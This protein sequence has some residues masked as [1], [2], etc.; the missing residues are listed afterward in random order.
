MGLIALNTG[1]D[2]TIL[3]GGNPATVLKLPA[4]TTIGGSS[5][6]A[7]GYVTSTSANAMGAGRQGTTNPVLN[8]DASAALVVTGIN[9]VGAAAAA[10]LALVVTSSG[11]DE[12]LTLDAKGAGTILLNGTAT[13]AVLVGDA[14]NPAFSVVH[15]SEGTGVKVTSAAAASGVAV[16]AISSGTDENLTHNAKGAGTLTINGVAT[17]ATIIPKGRVTPEVTTI[18]GDGAITIQS[19][20]VFLTKGSPA[21]I[22]L[23]APS[24]NDGVRICVIGASDFQHVI[25]FTGTTLLDGTTGANLK[26]TLAAFAGSGLVVI[27]KGANWYVESNNLTTITTT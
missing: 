3:A 17:G 8:V 6:T 20:T 1:E 4:N 22:T 23:A 19:G 16:A 27:A 24:S 5:V 25:T 13:G 15:T 11:T 7:L 21:A 26:S 10:G 9:V 2:G 12:S 18:T 14:T